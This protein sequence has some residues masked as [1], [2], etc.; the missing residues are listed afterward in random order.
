MTAPVLVGCLLLVV[1][2]ALKLR[3]PDSTVGALRSVGLPASAPGARALGAGEVALGTAAALVG[4]P[5]LLAL[6]AAAYAGFTAFVAR[7]LAS[8]GSV[9]SCGCVGRPDT[10]PTVTHLVVTTG[11][12]VSAAVAAVQGATGDYDW[13]TGRE[14]SADTIALLALTVL[15]T[16]L[17]WL[18]LAVLPQTRPSAI[19]RRA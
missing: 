9:A 14:P 1:A 12:A 17:T 11:L 8:G 18:A 16:W 13:V 5:V 10:P 2:G 6:L 19:R 7:A 4:H 3:R 15:A